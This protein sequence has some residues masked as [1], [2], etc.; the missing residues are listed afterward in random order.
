METWTG[1]DADL[2]DVDP[3]D[4]GD[5]LP[6]DSKV[7]E[8]AKAVAVLPMVLIGGVLFAVLLGMVAGGFALM[9]MAF[10]PD[11]SGDDPF[12]ATVVRN[13]RCVESGDELIEATVTGDGIDEL[14][15]DA[16]LDEADD[17]GQTVL[18]C[19]AAHG[20]NGDVETLLL[21]G[22]DPNVEAAAGTP[23]SAAAA[24]GHLAVAESLLEAGANVDGGDEPQAALARAIEHRHPDLV[25]L[26]LAN[27]A[28]ATEGIP[29]EM[30]FVDGGR[31]TRVGE[32]V[33][34]PPEAP[35]D[36]LVAVLL[37]SGELPL[38]PLH[39]AALANDAEI[40]QLL[41]DAGADPNQWVYAGVTPLHAATVADSQEAVDVL[42]DAG[43][44]PN[45]APDGNTGS[46]FGLAGALAR[47]QIAQRMLAGDTS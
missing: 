32:D 36:G 5:D 2:D 15:P 34:E 16:D 25:S 46:P 17:D 10:A 1:D 12:A 23:L 33:L 28:S 24:R 44:D 38:P 22:A 6:A 37:L 41:I 40:V 29:L 31:L 8:V 19:A 39:A 43:A 7:V 11:D 45:A 47:E 20:E 27:G 35:T 30:P 14:E 18:Y 21:A 3:D 42:L 9:G 4:D 13:G 26:L